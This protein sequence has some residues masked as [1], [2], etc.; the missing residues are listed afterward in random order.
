MSLQALYQE[1]WLPGVMASRLDAKFLGLRSWILEGSNV[2]SG[3]YTRRLAELSVADSAGLTAALVHDFVS[4]SS[5]AFESAAR[6]HQGDGDERGCAWQVV[7]YYYSAYFAANALMRLSGFASTNLD[8]ENCA[9]LN[10]F[11]SLCGVG[12]FDDASKLVPGVHFVAFDR[13]STPTLKIQA[14]NGVKGG[15]HIQ[16]WAAFMMF[17]AALKNALLASQLPAIDKKAARAQLDNLSKALTRSGK[18]NGNWLSEIRNGVN[19]RFE[20]GVWYPYGPSSTTRPVLRAVLKRSIEGSLSISDP[21][22]VI[23]DCERMTRVSG[24]LL[25]W[26][27]ASVL[28]LDSTA[29]H[30]KRTALRDG[31]L[32]FSDL[33]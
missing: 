33:I 12:G 31:V 17:I 11:A 2:P 3:R 24:Y 9:E 28:V 16:F 25:N 6:A 14:M 19:Y 26:L 18:N 23:A 21:A 29:R 20:N 4:L 15:V 5:A 30:G 22:A 13:A 10:E 7:A 8:A 27:Q 1:S 32:A